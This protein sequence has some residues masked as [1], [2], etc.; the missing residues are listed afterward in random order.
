ML[1]TNCGNEEI[2]RI[3]ESFE[4]NYAFDGLFCTAGADA[5]HDGSVVTHIEV[6]D[7]LVASSRDIDYDK[8]IEFLTEEYSSLDEDQIDRL[9][10]LTA[11]ECEVSDDD[12]EAFHDEFYCSE[13]YELAFEMQ[14]IRGLVARSQGFSAIE[15]SDEY[16]T[17]YL[18]MANTEYKNC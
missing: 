10:E 7:E 3:K 2:T 5:Q 9:Y 1:L 18:V 6:K 11:E 15:M 4:G 13:A 14:N 16:G 8:A 17:S 12:I